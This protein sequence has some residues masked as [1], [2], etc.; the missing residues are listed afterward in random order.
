MCGSAALASPGPAAPTA[1]GAEHVAEQA[2]EQIGKAAQ[3]AEIGAEATGGAG[4][5]RTAD[6]AK[7]VVLRPLLRI[8]QHGV[9]L[10]NPLETLLKPLLRLPYFV[11]ETHRAIVQIRCRICLAV[12]HPLPLTVPISEKI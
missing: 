10:T 7:T 12:R 3:V 11:D 1:A 8:G 9:G 6:E 5:A 2:L 4:G